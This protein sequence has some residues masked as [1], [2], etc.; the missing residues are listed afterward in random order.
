MS[1]SSKRSLPFGFSER[2]L[3][4]KIVVFWNVMPCSLVDTDAPLKHQ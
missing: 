3:Y 1:V 4:M 2:I